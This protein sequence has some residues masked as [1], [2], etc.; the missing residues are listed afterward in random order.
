V[1]GLLCLDFINTV[2]WRGR[3]NPLEFLN[4][5]SDLV[6][7]SRHAGIVKPKEAKQL[8]QKA[9]NHPLNAQTVLNEAVSFRETLYRI[10]IS[11]FEKKAPGKKDLAMLNVTLSKT[12]AQMKLVHAGSGFTWEPDSPKD[13]LDGLL[14]A[15]IRSA[16][17]L[18]VSESLTRVKRC[19]DSDCGW[20]YLDTSKNRSRRWCDMTDCGNRAKA[21]RFYKRKQNTI[22]TSTP[23]EKPP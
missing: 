15:V 13:N 14:I 4:A 8:I 9:S 17:D 1:G 5:Y 10:F 19:T 3:K 18:L 7:W 23:R 6:A 2:D 12:M 21:N 22:N 11:I 20:L 16:S